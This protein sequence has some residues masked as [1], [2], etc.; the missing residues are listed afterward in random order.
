MEKNGLCHLDFPQVLKYVVVL[1]H[2]TPNSVLLFLLLVTKLTPSI[3]RRL[4]QKKSRR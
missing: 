2:R 4:C 1:E 3:G